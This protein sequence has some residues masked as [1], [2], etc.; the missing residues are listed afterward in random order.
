MIKAKHPFFA[1]NA[2]DG[3]IMN[4]NGI[5]VQEKH[6]HSIGF[7]VPFQM[8]LINSSDRLIT[9]LLV[10]FNTRISNK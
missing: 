2:M 9:S 5:V 7:N 1:V 6:E 3:P 8:K 4:V 10:I